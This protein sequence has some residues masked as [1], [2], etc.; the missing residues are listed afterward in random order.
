[1]NGIRHL[2]WDL[3]FMFTNHATDKANRTVLIATVALT[4]VAWVA[5]FGAWEGK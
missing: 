1:M 3:G 5:G 2:L 4:L